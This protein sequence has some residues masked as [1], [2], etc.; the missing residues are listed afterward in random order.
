ATRFHVAG[1]KLQLLAHYYW[2]TRDTGYVRARE[3]VCGPVAD[4]IVTSR[5]PDNGLLPKDNYAGDIS[6]QVYALSSNANCW[7]GLRDLAAILADMGEREKSEKLARAAQEFRAAIL[8]AVAASERRDARP[9][10]IPN[11]LLDDEAP[12]EQMTAT[13]LGS[14]YSLMMPYV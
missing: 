2:V 5:L 13:R 14:Y 4:L 6:R 12:Y 3:P 9:P 7:R 11:A 10:F 1:H 8:R